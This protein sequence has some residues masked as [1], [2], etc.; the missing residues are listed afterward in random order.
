MVVI[1]Q[2]LQVLQDTPL[3]IIELSLCGVMIKNHQLLVES[4][5]R[6]S[7]LRSL[8]LCG[9]PTLSDDT[10]QEVEI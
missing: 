8:W 1:V 5:T 9:V 6:L 10:L 3:S 4:V 2:C 7:N